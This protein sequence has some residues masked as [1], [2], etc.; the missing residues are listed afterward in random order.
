MALIRQATN[1]MTPAPTTMTMPTPTPTAIPTMALTRQPTSV[2]TEAGLTLI[3]NLPFQVGPNAS[4]VPELVMVKADIDGQKCA[5]CFGFAIEPSSRRSNVEVVDEMVDAGKDFVHVKDLVGCSPGSTVTIPT[6]AGEAKY[7]VRACLPD[8]DDFETPDPSARL[9]GSTKKTGGTVLLSPP[10]QQK[11]QPGTALVISPAPS[12]SEPSCFASEALVHI[13][14][15]AAA[16]AVKPLARLETGDRV[17][18]SSLL[19]GSDSDDRMYEDVIGFLHDTSSS[20]A[21]MV[22]IEHTAGGLRVSALHILP[23]VAVG[24]GGGGGA[25]H[26]NAADVA[27]GDALVLPGG[28]MAV[29][30]AATRDASSFGVRAPLTASGYIVV[31]N[32][33]ASNYAVVAGLNIP[34]A[35]LHG[36]FFA[37]RLYWSLAKAFGFELFEWRSSRM[38]VEEVHPLV[39]LYYH[40]LRLDALLSWLS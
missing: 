15:A 20:H 18:S 33:V 27:V 23:L 6:I 26:K 13:E 37:A 29:V 36:C 12:E 4:T 28:A 14:G 17:L 5:M 31:D 19:E 16:A 10:L 35:A 7:I 21:D 22:T 32:V 24:A 25:F 3:L 9:L 38:H 1:A 11:L 8:A 34:Q 40:T 39:T 2:P 30:I